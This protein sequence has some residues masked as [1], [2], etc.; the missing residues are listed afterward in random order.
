MIFKLGKKE[1]DLKIELIHNQNNNNENINSQRDVEL[2]PI[3][4]FKNDQNLPNV[5]NQ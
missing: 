4:D 2:N 3:R 1:T 5:D